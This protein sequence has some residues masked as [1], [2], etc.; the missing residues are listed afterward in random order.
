MK[1]LHSPLLVLLTLAVILGGVLSPTHAQTPPPTI[2][3][4]GSSV[5]NISLAEAESEAAPI[6][7]TWNAIGLRYGDQL[8]L[9]FSR[10]NQWYPVAGAE[11]ALTTLTG[12]YTTVI[13]PTLTFAPPTYRLALFDSAGNLLDQHL[14]SL[15]YLVS[16]NTAT[17]I[18]TFSTASTTAALTSIDIPVVWT[19]EN[20]QPTQQL[21]FEQLLAD[22]SAVSAEKPRP[23][24]WIPSAGQ[25]VLSIQPAQGNPIRL[26]LSVRDL[27]TN[28]LIDSLELQVEIAEE[29]ASVS[30]ATPQPTLAITPSGVPIQPVVLSFTATPAQNIAYGQSIRLAWETQNI[31]ALNLGVVLGFSPMQTIAATLPASGTFDYTLPD[32]TTAG[33]T[34][35][36]A[37]FYL[38]F[39]NAAGQTDQ[40]EVIVQVNCPIPFFVGGNLGSPTCPT[41]AAQNVQMVYQPFERGSMLWRADQRQIIVFYGDG[42]FAIYPDTFTD[43][44]NLALPI[45]PANLYV[46]QRGFGK[47]WL[48]D[49]SLQQQLGWATAVEQSYTSP[50]QT[51]SYWKTTRT[52]LTFSNGTAVQLVAEGSNQMIGSWSYAQP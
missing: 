27:T 40:R 50:L 51:A 18:T 19:V 22:G 41:Q 28:S 6:T 46:P 8:A 39:T 33:S 34:Y 42:K 10:L 9:Q 49:A 26:R 21:V 17:K 3:S 2:L 38:T 24:L 43:G 16:L 4:F 44:D 1:R 13:Q 29:V 45:P 37:T 36:R 31:N 47:V 23:N 12:S 52:L 11:L 32:P 5:A 25:G 48:G 30:T 7:F 14:L 15:P 35:A 20:R